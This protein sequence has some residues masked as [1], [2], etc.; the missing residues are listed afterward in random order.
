MMPQKTPPSVT[1]AETPDTAPPVDRPR[2]RPPLP[3]DP[4]RRAAGEH[5]RQATLRPTAGGWACEAPGLGLWVWGETTDQARDRW[6][7]MMTQRP[8]DQRR[9]A[10]REARA[11]A[12]REAEQR[13]PDVPDW[14]A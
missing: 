5:V 13:D 7:E 2:W 8:R 10:L 3:P 9:W 6:L 14:A 12:A 4:D 1:D 11:A